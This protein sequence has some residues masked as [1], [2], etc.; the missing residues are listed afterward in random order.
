MLGKLPKIA[1]VLMS[2]ALAAE[3]QTIPAGARLTVRMASEIS[4]GT[5]KAGDRLDATLAHALVVNP[6]DPGQ[7]RGTGE[8]QG[9]LR[10]IEWTVACS[11]RTHTAAYFSTG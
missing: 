7:S 8:R 2:L 1:A 6:Q 11:G 10:E 4:S 9:D 3:A 5:A